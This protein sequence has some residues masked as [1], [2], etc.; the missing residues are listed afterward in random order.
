MSQQRE[1]ETRFLPARNKMFRFALRLLGEVQEAEDVVQDVLLK[2]W[3][4]RE[5]LAE[6]GN[7]EAWCMQLTR[8]LSL[9][10]LKSHRR[11]LRTTLEGWDGAGEGATPY[12]ATEVKDA[13]QR[14]QTAMRRLPET[15][16]AV[17]HLREVEGYSYQEMAEV[18]SLEMTQVKVYLHRARK[19]LREKLMAEE[20]YGLATD[21]NAG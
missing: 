11:K 16:R 13:M 12:R 5:K 18:L 15:Q 14:M 2:L 8:N 9:D 6:I 1:F 20:R 19:A 10:R 3:Q 17:I 7:A 21:R 4:Q